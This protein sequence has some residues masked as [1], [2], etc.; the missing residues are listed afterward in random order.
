[1]VRN[2][3]TEVATAEEIG[4]ETRVYEDFFGIVSLT[5][6]ETWP[7]LVE[8]WHDAQGYL[9][10]LMSGAMPRADPKAWE[11]YLVLL[12]PDD[13][14]A[15]EELEAV[16]A[17]RRNTRRV[18]KIIGTGGELQ[19]LPD[20][21]QILLPLLPLTVAGAGTGPPSA[22]SRL[23]EI[24]ESAGINRETTEAL[25]AAYASNDSLLDRLH[26]RTVAES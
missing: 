17:I 23:P 7:Q 20:V 10:D 2:G 18:R 9:V 1:L 5:V 25:L 16:D 15:E 11:G 22:L 21:E 6:F 4:L 13:P 12:T 3:Y 8:M 24:L 26:Q 19:T 14:S